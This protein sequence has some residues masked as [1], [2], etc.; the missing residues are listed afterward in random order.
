MSMTGVNGWYSA[1]R[2]APAGIDS[3]GTKPLPKN[4]RS[5]AASGCCWR[6]RRSGESPIAT[7]SQTRAKVAIA[8]TP[9]AAIHSSDV[10]VGRNPTSSAT[11]SDDREADHR[12]EE[13]AQ[14]RAR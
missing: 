9:S 4:G 12:L 2:A 5:T 1:N 11:P 8:S 7:E 10:A 6:S 14:R 13:A 3:V